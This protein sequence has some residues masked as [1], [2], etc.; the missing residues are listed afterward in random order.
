VGEYV[1][2]L[3]IGEELI[4]EL[5]CVDRL[6]EEHLGQC[7]NRAENIPGVSQGTLLLPPY[8]GDAG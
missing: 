6:G 3:V 2:D 8:I 7:I 5:K 4:V 1:A